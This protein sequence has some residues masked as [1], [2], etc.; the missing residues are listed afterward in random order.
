MLLGISRLGAC[1]RIVALQGIALGILPL[2]LEHEGLDIRLILFAAILV[3][4]KGGVFPWLLNRTLRDV[5]V[6][7]EIEPFVGYGFSILFGP[8]ALGLCMWLSSRLAIP[9]S[10]LGTKII[11]AA[12]F[13]MMTGLFLIITR[14]KASRRCWIPGARKRHFRFRRIAGAKTAADCGIGNFAG[15]FYGGICDGYC[16]VPY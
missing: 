3:I 6:Q 15:C 1:V 13:T 9:E 11:S 8:A 10:T 12:F 4:L 5:K 7:R 16:N 2:V 14:K